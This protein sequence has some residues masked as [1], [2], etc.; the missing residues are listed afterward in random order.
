MRKIIKYI[1]IIIFTVFAGI[2]LNNKLALAASAEIELS[3]DSSEVKVGDDVYVYLRITSDVMF[4]NFETNLTYDDDI[5]EYREGASVI[6]GSSGFLRISDFG[7]SEESTNRKYTMMFRAAAPGTTEI[8]FSGRAMVYDYDNGDE[9]P[10]SSNVL[11]IEVKPAETASDNALL[12]N[13]KISPTELTPEFKNDVY[14]YGTSVGSDIEQLVINAV[15]EDSKAVVSISGNDLLK[16]GENKVIIKVTAETGTVKEYTINVYREFATD[17]DAEPT[18]APDKSQSIFELVKISGEVYAIYNGRYKIVEPASDVNI[19]SGYIKT[20]A[21][22][23]GVSID[24][25]YPE[26][27]MENEFFL[28]YAENALGEKGFYSYDRI[29]KTIQR[30]LENK[31]APSNIV[32]PEDEAMNSKE[33]KENLTKAG[34]VIAVL[35]VISAVLIVA[36]IR[37]YLKSNS[38][39]R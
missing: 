17:D 18:I 36:Y 13:L 11:S 16:E 27:D 35:A 28:I 33:Y 38:R 19:P 39:K 29:E 8:S 4:G 14:E 25:Y 10:V 5:L 23:S 22:I 7:S 3:T 34:I 24:A 6:T 31:K 1:G 12:K 15:P 2:I 20:K 9:M 26:N 30:F 37:L 32:V 21:I